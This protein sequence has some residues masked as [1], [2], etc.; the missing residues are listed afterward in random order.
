MEGITIVWIIIAW[1]YFLPTLIAWKN[2]HTKTSAIF[3]LNLF[4]G[5]CGVG[6]LACLIWALIKQNRA[7]G[8]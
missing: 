2:S 7:V 8:E 1:L 6:W 5:W 3:A 4:L